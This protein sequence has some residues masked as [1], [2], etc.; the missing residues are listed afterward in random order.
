MLSVSVGQISSPTRTQMTARLRY[1]RVGL[2]FP[3]YSL[4]LLNHRHRALGRGVEQRAKCDLCVIGARELMKEL[5]WV[6]DPQRTLNDANGWRK[7]KLKPAGIRISRY[8]STHRLAKKW[9]SRRMG[10]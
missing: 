3:V 9:R 1:L 5:K 4:H 10:A 2:A 8:Y 6:I 7:S